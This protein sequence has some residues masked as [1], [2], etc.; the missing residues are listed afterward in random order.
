MQSYAGLANA[1]VKSEE[2]ES[3]IVNF[4]SFPP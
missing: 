2:E 3:C 1:Q 4:G